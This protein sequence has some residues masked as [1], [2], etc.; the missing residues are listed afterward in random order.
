M[1]DPWFERALIL[2]CQHNDEGAIGIII[3][4]QGDVA[5]QEVIE[6]LAEDHDEFSDLQYDTQLTWWGGPVGQGAGFV[7]FRGCVEDG[8]G[9]N[10]EG[11]AV[12]PSLDRLSALIRE[13]KQF[14]LCLGYAGWGPGQLSDEIKSGSW[15]AVDIDPEI[16]FDT[17]AEE[18]YEKAL[19]QIGL[20]PETVWMTPIDE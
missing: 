17:P 4:K 18:R 5:V 11:V 14:E 10:V 15:L 3:N 19:A 7:L 16:V 20:T 1:H 2:V 12:S 8:E 9:W 13:G 6:R